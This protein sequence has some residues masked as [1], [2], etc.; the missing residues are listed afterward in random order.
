MN[1]LNTVFHHDVYLLGGGGLTIEQSFMPDNDMSY[2]PTLALGIGARIFLPGDR[3]IRIQFR[4]DIMMQS[5]AKTED[6]Q[7]SFLKQNTLVSVGY[8]LLRK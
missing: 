2:S 1:V 7:G 3:M 8:T 6:T 5:R 4:D